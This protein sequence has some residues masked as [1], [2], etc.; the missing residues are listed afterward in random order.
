MMKFLI[1]LILFLLPCFVDAQIRVAVPEGPTGDAVCSDG[2]DNDMDG[3]VDNCAGSA[4]WTASGSDYWAEAESCQKVSPIGQSNDD[5]ASGAAYLG[6]GDTQ[7]FGRTYF[8]CS[9]T[10]TNATYYLWMRARVNAQNQN[11]VWVDTSP[12]PYTP[13]NTK[14]SILFPGQLSTTFAWTPIGASGNIL[15][16]TNG[17]AQ[18][19][20]ALN[21]AG[22][23]YIACVPGCQI[24]R[25]VLSPSSSTDPSTVGAGGGS[26]SVRY[27]ILDKGAASMASK[28][29]ATAFNGAN[30]AAFNGFSSMTDSINVKMLHDATKVYVCATVLDA[31][32]VA[33][34]TANDSTDIF[35]GE[36]RIEIVFK[37]NQTATYDT[38]TGKIGINLNATPAQYDAMN[39]GDV[40]GNWTIANVTRTVVASTSWSLYF[41]YTPPAF[42]ADQ[43]VLGNILIGD[44]DAAFSYALFEGA[45]PYGFNTLNTWALMKYSS[46]TVPGSAD[47]T[48]PTV[49]TPTFANAGTS[50]M[51]VLFT[52]TETGTG[53]AEYG[54]STGVYDKISDTVNCGATCTA[55]I[56]KPGDPSLL[57]STTYFVRGKATD[58]AGNTGTS[59]EAN[60]ATAAPAGGG[61]IYFSTTGNDTTGD[62]STGNPYKTFAKLATLAAPG[63]TFILKDGT[64][65]TANSGNGLLANCNAV[66]GNTV[67][68]TVAN[69][70]IVK[71]ENERASIIANDGL[72]PGAITVSG[73]S[74]WRFHGI[75]AKGADNNNSGQKANV[76]SIYNSSNIWLQRMLVSHNNRY[77]NSHLLGLAIVSNTLVEETEFYS[78]HRGGLMITGTSHHNTIRRNYANGRGYPDLIGG[79]PSIGAGADESFMAYG[80]H[81]NLFENNICEDNS[82]CFNVQDNEFSD[83]NRFYGNIGIGAHAIVKS[84]TTGACCT[85]EDNL[86][87]DH[88]VISR[89]GGTSVP[90]YHR[91]HKRTRCD[92]CSIFAQH[93]N[94]ALVSD[95]ESG[96]GDGGPYSFLGN[97]ILILRSANPA[98]YGAALSTSFTVNYI[99]SYGSNTPFS[100]FPSASFTNTSTNDPVMGSCYAWIPATSNLKGAG[101]GGADIGAN[102]LYA[103]QDG[104]LTA[105]K[106]WDTTNHTFVTGFKGATVAGVNDVAGS[107]LANIGAR[108]HLGTANGCAYPAGY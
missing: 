58:A 21:G 76:I 52:T 54:T 100:P 96:A 83:N 34:T 80:A 99:R 65:S 12:I 26:S 88:V 31:S 62:G 32:V 22:T 11:V 86:Y 1:A 46:T 82:V 44:M 8:K 107:S 72:S 102:V 6:L 38:N 15:N 5:T 60:Q 106:L 27:E 68:G 104:V 94:A 14:A 23:I 16:Q 40:A 97:N 92:N 56:P 59:A 20:Y 70:I 63:K 28:C 39:N 103:Y 50:S 2:I 53:F 95:V 29:A 55:H 13:L 91:T 19:S 84:Y 69:P 87:R 98:N 45:A 48:A 85:P 10:F 79:Y 41:E 7:Q 64:Y 77:E 3:L 42:T 81:D 71:A 24:D 105:N 78:Y 43:I 57:P 36:D 35:G 73:C 9:G 101:L 51:D 74:Y 89:V 67:S 66:G 33:P 108:L 18:A 90:M 47:V 25:L 4:A 75:Y 37:N 30:V 61:A 49:G 17:T 93:N